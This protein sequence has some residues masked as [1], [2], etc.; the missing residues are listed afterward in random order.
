MTST[1]SFLCSD[2]YVIIIIRA[3]I[4]KLIRDYIQEKNHTNVTGPSASGDLPGLMNWPDTT[5]NIQV[6][7]PSDVLSAQEA[8]P[9]QVGITI[10][11]HVMIVMSCMLVISVSNLLIHRIQITWHFMSRDTTVIIQNWWPWLM[12]SWLN[13]GYPPHIISI[14]ILIRIIIIMT[15]IILKLSHDLLLLQQLNHDIILRTLW[16][17]IY[18]RWLNKRWW[19]R[20]SSSH[21]WMIP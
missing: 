17:I 18:D 16:Q 1:L 14:R 15:I 11:C 20:W 21:D 12:D 19:W 13:R 7:D 10:L 5:G 4:W 3:P 8:L 9:D 6:I 2:H